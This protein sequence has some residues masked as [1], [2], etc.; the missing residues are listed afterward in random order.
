LRANGEAVG[1]HLI[2]KQKRGFGISSR[3][4]IVADATGV[5]VSLVFPPA[6]VAAAVVFL[7]LCFN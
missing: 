5:G 1:E 3:V 2:R 4:E 7:P 6:A